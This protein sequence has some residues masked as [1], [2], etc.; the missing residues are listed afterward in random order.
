MTVELEGA[1]LID[2]FGAVGLPDLD[3][4][5]IFPAHP[6]VCTASGTAVREGFLIIGTI[7]IH[8]HLIG[9]EVFIV[10]RERHHAHG[11]RRVGDKGLR[12]NGRGEIS[13]PY[14]DG[15]HDSVLRNADL[16]CVDR[17]RGRGGGAIGGVV[18]GGALWRGQAQ[19]DR[20]GL[21][22]VLFREGRLFTQTEIGRGGVG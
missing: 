3:V 15:A 2:E 8:A 4:D 9:E 7:G 17:G 20:G 12:R 14:S 5:G 6:E 13:I 1:V 10:G 18:D 16:P 11:V 22:A 19:I 21:E